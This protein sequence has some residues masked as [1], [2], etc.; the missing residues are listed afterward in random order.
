MRRKLANCQAALVWILDFQIIC[1]VTVIH[2]ICS[3]R[4]TESGYLSSVLG[5]DRAAPSITAAGPNHNKVKSF[6]LCM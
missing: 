1:K 4:T 3:P 2:L 5:A 6:F